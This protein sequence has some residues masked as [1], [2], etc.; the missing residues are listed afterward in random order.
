VIERERLYSGYVPCVHLVLRFNK[1]SLVENERE[2]ESLRGRERGRE[3]EESRERKREG[4][5]QGER[6]LKRTVVKAHTARG[7]AQAKFRRGIRRM[8][9]S[10]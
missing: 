8:F 2:R 10:D 7:P 5:G 3:R 9:Y 6:S 1:V 4:R